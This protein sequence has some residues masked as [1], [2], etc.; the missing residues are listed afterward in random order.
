L[1][2]S[3]SSDPTISVYEVDI[4]SATEAIMDARQLAFLD[5]IEADLTTPKPHSKATAI[6]LSAFGAVLA[7]SA[8]FFTLSP[9]TPASAA[10]VSAKATGF[11]VLVD[12]FTPVAVN[13]NYTKDC[14]S[15]A[16]VAFIFLRE[17][18]CGPGG[19]GSIYQF[20][21]TYYSACTGIVDLP[22]VQTPCV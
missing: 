4:H 22:V 5:D 18:A 14:N 15:G 10:P 12:C 3:D 11:D 8:A 20:S 1:S 21:R 9:A 19:Q 7:A 6:R 2:E 17:W 13:N 16:W